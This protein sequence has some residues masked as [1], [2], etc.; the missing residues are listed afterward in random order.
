MANQSPG[1]RDLA[2]QLAQL[3]RRVRSIGS[4][5]QLAHSAIEDGAVQ[6]YDRD[7]QQVM[8]IGKQWDG[9]YAPTVTNGPVPP[10][11]SAPQVLDATEGIVVGWDGSFAGGLIPTPMDFL[12]VD[13]HV[14]A[15]SDFIPDHSN[16]RATFASPQGGFASITLGYGTYWVKLVLWTLAGKVSAASTA[17]EGDAWPVEVSSDGF[18]PASSPDPEVIGGLD[19]LHVRWTPITNADPVTYDVH[20]SA[21][22]GFT[23]DSTTLAGSTDASMFSIRALPGPV[24]PEGEEDPRR[25]QYGVDY[26]VKLIA[27]DADGPA[28]AGMQGSARIFQVTGVNLAADSVTA[29]NIVFGSIVGEH[30]SS[31]V[32]LAGSIKTAET[33]QRIELSTTGMQAYKSDNSLMINLPTDPAQTALLDA[34]VVARALTATGP[35][36][37]R[38][39]ANSVDKDAVVKLRNGIASPAATPQM[40][41]AYN[42]YQFSTASLTVAQKTGELGTF[43]FQ[44]TEVS[45][46]EWK[47]SF[48]YWVVHQIR[49]GGTRAWFFDYDGTPW[50]FG[51]GYFTDY[52]DWEIWSVTE[53]TTSSVPAKNG[54]YRI[55]RWIPSGSANTYYIWS[56]FGLNRYSRQNNQPPVVGNNGQDM[57]VAEVVSNQLNIRYFATLTGDQ[58]NAVPSTVYQSSTGF[59]S[60]HP[61]SNVTYDAAGFDIGAPRYLVSERGF[62][63]VNKLVYTSGTNAG[64]I[65]PGG[66][67]AGAGSWSSPNVNAETFEAAHTNPRCSAWDGS[68]FWTMGG[69]GKMYQY[70]ETYWDPSV[71][72]SVIWMQHTFKDNNAAGTGQHETTPGPAKSI[73]WKRRSKIRVFMPPIP[74]A[75]GVDEPNAVTVYA[76]RGASQPANS[77]F[78]IQYEGNTPVAD[79]TDFDFTD[80]IPPTVN[81]FPLTNPGKITDDAGT[82]VIS[83]DGTIKIGGKDVALGAPVIQYITSSGTWT[84]PA[85]LKAAY[86]ECVG[87]GGGSGGAASGTG[88]AESGPGGGGA[89]SAKMYLAGDLSATESVTIGAGGN[90]GT[91]AGTAGTNGGSTVF[92]GQTAG[93]GLGGAAAPTRAATMSANGGA[94]GT[95]TGGD[96]NLSGEGGGIGRVITSL[97]LLSARGGGSPMG[98]GT[99]GVNNQ[100]AQGANPGAG[101]GAGGGPVFTAAN[102]QAG[103]PGTQGIIK[104]TCYF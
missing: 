77:G 49:P 83:G 89:Y 80:P 12:R 15:T 46:I 23:P 32:I 87:G 41:I 63:V 93:P 61:L 91:T 101:Y 73:T 40:S 30:L 33:G 95:A 75:G 45:C 72:S 4:T 65:H 21:T 102:A 97:A 52:V 11:P 27:R 36:T 8:L 104:I 16:R 82:M 35:V 98:F 9:T 84:K 88:Q 37:M 56:P 50:D 69:D 100:G 81:S 79:F 42:T 31:S 10:T 70:A 53:M 94:G 57:Y 48:N 68:N 58:S 17:T 25:L 64:S 34:E 62:S 18:A 86:V 90:A 19:L 7:G 13:V 6:A 59:T 14:G 76:G 5:G 99:G 60:T 44:G 43:D 85:G 103:A 29:A 20:V 66:V 39:N 22:D 74:G 55:A 3:D 78:H 38:S 67:A 26:Y 51:S 54:V 92:K 71:E 47:P 28:P 96:I 1:L 24:P 2:R